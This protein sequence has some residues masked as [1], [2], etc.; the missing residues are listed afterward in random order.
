MPESSEAFEDLL[1]HVLSSLGVS[2][3]TQQ[4]N[5]L[6]FHY[7]LLMQWNR[8]MNL[9]AIRDPEEVVRRHFGESLFLAEF[10][11]SAV[12]TLVDVGSGAGFPGIP[13]A[14]YRPNLHVTLV[15][16]VAKKATFLREATRA[17]PNV[18]VLNSRVE[19]LGEHFDWVV[20]R[21]VAPA[22]VLPRLVELA[23]NVVLLVTAKAVAEL[24]HNPEISWQSPQPLP[25]SQGRVLLIG[26]PRET[27]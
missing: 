26:V 4:V 20:M 19:T 18:R 17:L 15:E 22:P 23:P 16:S 21:A 5:Q 9:S 8:K 3:S 14:V 2:L 11:P 25:W 10:L 24:Q 12:G 1:G 27:S 7:D 13:V 6:S